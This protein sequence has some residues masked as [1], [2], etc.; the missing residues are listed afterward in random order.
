MSRIQRY[1]FNNFDLYTG[2][3]DLIGQV[4]EITLPVLEMQ[5]EEMRNAGMV[6][7]IDVPMGYSKLE[8]SFKMPNV[9]PTVLSLYGVRLDGGGTPFMAT[10]SLRDEDGGRHTAVILMRGY[11]SKADFGTWKPGEIAKTDYTVTVREYALTIDGAPIIGVTPYEVLV[12]GQVI[13]D[14]VQGLLSF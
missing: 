14:G 13:A 12:A 3:E 6:M 5:Q 9:S 1:V 2:A 11:L 7:P 4:E 8:F 10:G